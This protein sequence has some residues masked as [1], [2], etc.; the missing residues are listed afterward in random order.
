MSP[1]PSTVPTISSPRNEVPLTTKLLASAPV[2]EY[3]LYTLWTGVLPFL[4]LKRWYRRCKLPAA[5]RGFMKH[6]KNFSPF[7]LIALLAS[8]CASTGPKPVIV[9]GAGQIIDLDNNKSCTI[10]QL[11][12]NNYHCVP[13]LTREVA[14]RPKAR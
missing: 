12:K 11:G 1:P 8:A 14:S 7:V 4:R 5:T 2:S 10:V 9:T 13:S 6:I 3:T